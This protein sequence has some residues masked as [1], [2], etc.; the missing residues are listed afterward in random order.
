MS[1]TSA[2]CQHSATYL[3]VDETKCRTCGQSLTYP[4]RAPSPQDKKDRARDIRLLAGELRRRDELPVE[5][6]Q[7]SQLLM[8]HCCQKMLPQNDFHVNN[9]QA[10]KN[11]NYRAPRCRGC[12]AFRLRVKRQLNPE[13]F[14]ERGKERRAR[15][16]AALT[17]EQRELEKQR[18]DTTRNAAAVK[19]YQA[20]RAGTP[21]MVQKAGRPPIHIKPIC[22]IS[23]GCPLRR[24]CTIENKGL[25]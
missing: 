1:T 13:R 22:R 20:R 11:R 5:V 7:V 19:R 8:C 9:H 16:Q 2:I 23:E 4:R 3:D 14:R 6:V 12:I 24:F 25:A 21:V 10:A 17:P 18:R 15:Y